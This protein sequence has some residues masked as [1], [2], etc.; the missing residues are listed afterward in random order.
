[1]SNELQQLLE[2]IRQQSGLTDPDRVTLLARVSTD[3]AWLHSRALAGED[4]TA[5]MA[6]LKA[7]AANL[8]EHARGVVGTQLLAFVQGLIS[9]ALGVAILG[10]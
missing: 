10:A 9:R 8:D 3:A 5:E 4:V 6:I 2:R 7:T 1:M